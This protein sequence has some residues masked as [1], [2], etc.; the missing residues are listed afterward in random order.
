MNPTP[1]V[2]IYENSFEGLLCAFAAADREELEQCGF[3]VQGEGRTWLWPPTPVP[4]QVETAVEFLE[5]L[6]RA[7]GRQAVLH[8]MYG[9][10]AEVQKAEQPLYTFA[11]QTLRV[12][13][14]VLGMRTNTAVRQVADWKLKVG[15]EAHRMTGLLRFMELQDGTLY[16]RFEP[17]HNV[18]LLVT[19]HFQRRFPLDNWVIHDQ[20]RGLAIAWDGKN[21]HPVVGVP[22][23]V[24]DLLSRREISFQRLWQEYVQALAV[25]E[26]HNPRL[27]RRFMPSRYWKHL[28]EQIF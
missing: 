14:S 22:G 27:Q 26:R 19:S 11:L 13:K 23:N 25:P 16:A 21:L 24:D 18:L 28:V 3:A 17:D 15:K 6:R 7:G 1:R 4:V 5:R 12:G 10:L 8:M 20:R 2:F 9:F